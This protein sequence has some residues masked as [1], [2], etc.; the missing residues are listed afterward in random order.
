MELGHVFQESIFSNFLICYMV[1]GK[2]LAMKKISY[3]ENLE[4]WMGEFDFYIPIKVR[5]SETDMF[6]HL[7]NTVP[8]IYFEQARIELI[9]RLGVWDDWR[10]G[11]VEYIP[12]VA[13][14]QCDYLAQVFFGE[15]L[16]VYVKVADVGRSSV[17][18]HYMAKKADGT[19]CLTG[20][21]TLVKINR[22]TGKSEPWTEEER[23]MME[24]G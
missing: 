24:K 7:N 1:K 21:G 9:N 3:I 12:I 15:E 16:K 22:K 10:K 20:R 13:D 14:L 8:F 6:G 2:G 18:L 19:L 23:R 17:D 5:F 11:E 4:R